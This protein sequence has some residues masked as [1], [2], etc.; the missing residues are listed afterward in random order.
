MATTLTPPHLP[1]EL[2][3]P[4]SLRA[5][6][7]KKLDAQRLFV[8]AFLALAASLKIAMAW[9]APIGPDE[10][11]HLHAAWCVWMGQTP[12]VDF[13]E[14]HPPFLYYLLQPVF[15]LFSPDFGLIL[16]ARGMML[17]INLFVGY[18]TYLLAR[19]SFG[20]RT[21]WWSLALLASD[22]LFFERGFWV[23]TDVPAVLLTLISAVCLIKGYRSG[24]GGWFLASSS[25]LGCALLFTPKLIYLGIGVTVW[26]ALYVGS[27]CDRRQRTQ[28]LRAAGIYLAGGLVPWGILILLMGIEAMPAFWQSNVVLNLDWKARHA[29]LPHLRHMLVTNGPLLIAAAVGAWWSVTRLGR[30]ASRWLA[31]GPVTLYFISLVLGAA[32]L[33][34]VWE[35][36]VFGRDKGAVPVSA[37]GGAVSTVAKQLLPT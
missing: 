9:R 35:D 8:V 4:E 30:R 12:Y 31:S 20:R 13:F 23:L 29:P 3:T 24:Q 7:R 6:D 36:G 21:A 37:L 34:V 19:M 2:A 5:P 26:F 10:F 33:P 11:Q 28:R 32:L 27:A 14:H 16:A 18:V 25:V 17:L 22:F 1:T 15:W